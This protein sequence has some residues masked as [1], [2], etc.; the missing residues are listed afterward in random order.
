MDYREVVSSP[1]YDR[2]VRC[3]WFLTGRSNEYRPQP[4]VPDGRLELLVHR[5]DPFSRIQSNGSARVQDSALVAGQLTGPIHLQPGPI[6]DVMGIRLTPLGAHAILDLPLDELTNSVIPLRDV[7]PR[8]ASLLIT[9]SHRRASH[10]DRAHSITRHLGRWLAN[11][12][13]PLMERADHAL[14]VGTSVDLL[15]RRTGM[16]MRTLQRRFR[17]ETGL[18]PKVYQRV[19]R[20]RMAFSLLQEGRNGARV[21]AASGY[22]DQAHMIRDFTQF[23]GTSPGSFFESNPALARAFSTANHG[24]TEDPKT[25]Y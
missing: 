12:I 16:T 10:A 5:A 2:I 6:I 18:S 9:E 20:F 3:V 21:A 23:A 1:P 25:N 15:A 4:V 11:E 19:V 14:S 7:R 24:A 22:Y 13:D 17:R 8:L